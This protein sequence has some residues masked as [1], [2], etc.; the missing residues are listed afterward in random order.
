MCSERSG[1][2]FITKVMNGHEDICGPSTKHIINPV[3]RNFYRYGNLMDE[4]A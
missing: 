4:N 3:A 2:N 1:S